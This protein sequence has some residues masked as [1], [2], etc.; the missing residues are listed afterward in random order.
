MIV[1]GIIFLIITLVLELFLE[2][3]FDEVLVIILLIGSVLMLIFDEM[4]LR[5]IFNRDGSRK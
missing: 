3:L 5:K 4:Y 2:N 1:F